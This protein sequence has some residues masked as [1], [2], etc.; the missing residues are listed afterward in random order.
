VRLHE[1][2]LNNNNYNIALPKLKGLPIQIE[3][4]NG[5]VEYQ[6]QLKTINYDIIS[7]SVFDIPKNG[8]RILT[9]EQ[10]KKI[11]N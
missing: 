11:N 3:Y 7:L 2:E 6:Y 1:I 4:S 8:F 5:D 9:Y 10:A